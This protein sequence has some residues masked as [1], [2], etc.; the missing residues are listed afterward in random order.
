L[1]Y[2]S[3][4]ADEA[5]FDSILRNQIWSNKVSMHYSDQGSRADLSKILNYNAGAQVYTCG[6]DGYMASVLGI[7]EANG[8]P[9]D[10]LHMEYFAVPEQ[11][12][13]ENHAFTLKLAKSGRSFEIPADRTP[14]DV[15]QEAGVQIDV[16]CSDGICGVCKCQIVS[17][18]VEHRDFVLSNKQRESSLILCQSRAADPN[19]ILEIDI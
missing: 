7:A 11:P 18:D 14:T 19:G 12:E 16:K 10:N 6:P 3:S 9:Q 2:S 17:G 15:L 13:Y 8:F 1:H 5:A 4:K